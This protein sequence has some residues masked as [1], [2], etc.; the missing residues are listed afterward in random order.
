M[1]TEYVQR[2]MELDADDDHH[3]SYIWMR[4]VL[5]WP[6]Q[7]GEVGISL[8]SGQ[9]SKY[10]D[11]V[12]PTLP[13]VRLYQK[14]VWWDADLILDQI[15]QMSLSPFFIELDQVCRAEGVTYVIVWDNVRFHHAHVVQ[16]CFQAHAQFTTLY[17]PPYSPF[18]NPIEEFFSAWRW[19]VHDRHP[20]EQVT[21]FQAMDD[22]CNDITA[23]QCQAWIRYARRF[24]PR[25]LANENIH[26]DV[27]EQ[28]VAKSTTQS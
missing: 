22:A 9:P 27:D 6:R 13:C 19:K 24:F 14:M 16:A 3:K 1:R 20:H 23:D 17:L 21:L 5:I 2:V 18:L 4:Q 12:G 28:P 10:L 8:A 25:C 15:M 11:N 7:G 26:C